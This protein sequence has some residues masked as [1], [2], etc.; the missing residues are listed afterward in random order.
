[1]L[2]HNRSSRPPG[3]R[4]L[5]QLFSSIVAITLTGS[6]IFPAFSQTAPPAKNPAAPKNAGSPKAADPPRRS[7]P[8]HLLKECKDYLAPRLG[9]TRIVGPFS[10]A[11]FTTALSKWVWEKRRLNIAAPSI[12]TGPFG[13][14]TKGFVGCMFAVE[15]GKYEFVKPLGEGAFPPRTARAPGDPP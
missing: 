9:S 5:K 8:R 13:R 7:I 10:E 11:T 4:V 2:P 6:L 12:G 14:V 1:M 3:H 15:D